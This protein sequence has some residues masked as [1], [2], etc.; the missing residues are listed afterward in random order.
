MI[1]LD[2]DTFY[3]FNLSGGR[4]SAF[5][6]RKCL[7]AWHGVVPKNIKVIFTNT[8]RELDATLDF[9]RDIEINWNVPIV[10]LE[11]N[12]RNKAGGGVNDP[13]Y[14]FKIVNHKTANRSGKPFQ[15]L[16]RAGKFLPKMHRRICTYQLKI[17][18]VRRYMKSQGIKKY[19]SILGIRYDEPRRWEKALMTE[20]QAVYPLV[21]L[22]TTRTDVLSFWHGNSFDLQI[23]SEFSNC[24]FCFMKGQKIL[25]KTYKK[26]P[27]RISWWL[28]Q[29]QFIS[30][31]R[32]ENHYFL[33]NAS[34]GD[35]TK[36]E[37]ESDQLTFSCFCGD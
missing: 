27:E 9:L 1:K 36:G 33:K 31:L 18:T 15:E 23:D 5:M 4:S 17:E 29:E 3:S 25:Q 22:R 7:D 16:I 26:Y 10:W 8:G 30:E 21:S 11:F 14:W 6:L 13:K 34:I 19:K 12:Y 32:S 24:D 20:C 28:E 37:V 2:T 35:V